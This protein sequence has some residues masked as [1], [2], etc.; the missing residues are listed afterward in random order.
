PERW[1][2]YSRKR[3]SQRVSEYSICHF[4]EDFRKAPKIIMTRP[5]QKADKKN[6]SA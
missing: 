2:F 4:F 6:F 5:A 1:A 3:K